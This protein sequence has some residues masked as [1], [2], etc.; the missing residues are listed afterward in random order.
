MVVLLPHLV[1]APFPQHRQVLQIK[2]IGSGAAGG[3]RL[4][5]RVRLVFEFL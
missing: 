2:I 4:F 1:V 5:Q 3:I